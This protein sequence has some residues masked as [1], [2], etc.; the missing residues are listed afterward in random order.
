VKPHQSQQRADLVQGNALGVLCASTRSEEKARVA[1]RAELHQR[2]AANEQ[3]QRTRVAQLLR[4][5]AVTEEQAWLAT[6]AA[7]DAAAEVC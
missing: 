5:R 2:H 3:L 7:A 6:E 1:H 4:R